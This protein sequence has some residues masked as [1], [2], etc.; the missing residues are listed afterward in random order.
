MFC[1]KCGS[2]LVPK[3]EGNKKILACKCGYTDKDIKKAKIKETI[4]VE[5]KIEVIH[6]EPETLPKIKAECPKCKHK[7]AYYWT[8]QTRA[9]DEPETKFMKCVKC[10]KIWRDY[11]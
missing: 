9:G 5:K 8:A 10:E 2:L 7:E 11:S 1:P 6:K 4:H 3:Q